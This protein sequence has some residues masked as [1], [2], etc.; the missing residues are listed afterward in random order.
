VIGFLPVIHRKLQRNGL[1]FERIR[2]WAAVLPA[3]AQPREPLLIR[4]D[5]RNLSKL[6][7]LGPHHHYHAIPYAD[8]CHPPI[9]LAEFKHAHAML[10]NE[11]KAT[12]R[13]S[14]RAC[15]H[16]PLDSHRCVSRVYCG[17]WQ[18]GAAAQSL[19]LRRACDDPNADQALER[20]A[21]RSIVTSA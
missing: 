4:Y 8:V 18:A 10:R 13:Q 15:A 17:V 7:V 3:I 14:L 6:Y 19:L 5:P 2:Y 12:G 16:S 21:S 20:A 9:S 11:A 1:Y